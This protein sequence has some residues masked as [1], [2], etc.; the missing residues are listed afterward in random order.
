MKKNNFITKY[1][2][3][4][5]Q[6][7]FEVFR[8]PSQTEPDNAMSI[9]EIIARFTRGYGIEVP[10]HDWT[11]GSAFGDEDPEQFWD[12]FKPAAPAAQQQEQ[13]QQEGDP[14]SAD[15]AVKQAPEGE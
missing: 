4:V 10:Q 2:D 8:K 15:S 14:A 7:T 11:T 5:L 12:E 13:Q 9:P 1:D 6:G 3:S